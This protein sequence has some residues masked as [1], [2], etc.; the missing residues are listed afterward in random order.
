MTD[1]QEYKKTRLQRLAEQM[2]REGYT[3]DVSNGTLLIYEGDRGIAVRQEDAARQTYMMAV[4]DASGSWARQGLSEDDMLKEMDGIL[5][6]RDEKERY[7]K[8]AAV[9]ADRAR[10]IEAE[11]KARADT[12]MPRT[13]QET[14]RESRSLEYGRVIERQSLTSGK[15]YDF[16]LNGQGELT[17]Y[18][19]K[20]EA[21]ASQVREAE[22]A[23]HNREEALLLQYLMIRMVEERERREREQERAAERAAREPEGRMHSNEHRYRKASGD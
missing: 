18:D 4:K 15:K 11:D 17:Q 20:R 5:R 10:S 7:S 23:R 3:A 2:R 13:R 1:T 19:L 12:G 6:Q 21:Y 22:S 8:E 14:E 9:R 16:R